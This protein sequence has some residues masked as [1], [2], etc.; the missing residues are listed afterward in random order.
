MFTQL[1]TAVRVVQIRGA[2]AQEAAVVHV[3]PSL[4]IS[5][6]NILTFLGSTP[7]IMSDIPS[8]V[9]LPE[10]LVYRSYITLQVGKIV[11]IFKTLVLTG[12]YPHSQPDSLH[13]T[14]PLT[15]VVWLTPSTKEEIE[16]VRFTVFALIV[17]IQE[18]LLRKD[19]RLSVQQDERAMSSLTVSL[20]NLGMAQESL[21]IA[22][23]TVD[24]YKILVKADEDVYSPYL[25]FALR[26]LSA[27]FAQSGDLVNAYKAITE[28]VTLARRVAAS[29]PT[30]EAQSQLA[31]L[32][33][34]SAYVGRLNEDTTNALQDAE[35]AVQLY[36][37]LFG[38]ATSTLK[39]EVGVVEKTWGSTV[40][41]FEGTHAY[42]FAD[43]L[44]ELHYN[45]SS[46]IRKDE[47]V[48]AGIMA[49]E[50]YSTLG[51]R[52][53]SDCFSVAIASLCLSL[54]SDD[55]RD[56]ISIAEALSY[57]E[58]SVCHYESL[59]QSTGVVP[60]NLFLALAKEAAL[61]S[62]LERFDDA[63]AVCRKTANMLHDY[64]D[65]QCLR[66]Q[67]LRLLTQ[68]LFDSKH[69][70][71]AAVTGEHLLVTFQP[72]LSVCE[73]V[74]IREYVSTSFIW[75]GDYSKAV[76]VAEMSVTSCRALVLQGLQHP[77]YLA[78]SL[79]RLACAFS[80]KKDYNR[81]F[82]EGHTALEMYKSLIA[83]NVGFLTSYKHALELN[84]CIVRD[85]PMEFRSL[86]RSREVVQHCRALVKQFPNEQALFVQC[87]RDHALLLESFDLIAD[88]NSAIEEVLSWFE[89][90]PA[91]DVEL[92]T[93]HCD[94]LI[95]SGRFQRL[96]GCFDRAL[97]HYE[98]IIEIGNPF[99][100]DYSV[101]YNVLWAKVRKSEA[102]Y[103][104]GQ[105][106]Q[107]LG[108]TQD[109]LKFAFEHGLEK[110]PAYT[111][112]LKVASLIHRCS[113]RVDHA[114][115]I[116]RRSIVLDK[117]YSRTP[118]HRIL[119]DL[120]A[121]AGVDV[122]AL[123]IAQE[124]IEATKESSL[125]SLPQVKQWHAEAQYSLAIRLF[126]NKELAQARKFLRQVRSFYEHHSNARNLWFV[127]L[128]ITLRAEGLVEC[129][130]GQHQEGI[131]ARTQ[132]NELRK[133][134]R[135]VFP[136][137]A[138]LVE[139]GLSR[140]MNFATWRNLSTKYRLT[141]G[142]QDEESTCQKE[143]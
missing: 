8:H 135:F 24:L 16:D 79:L 39:A 119:S 32:V 10:D 111:S 85:A 84:M 50:L 15:S 28:A 40:M 37:R 36:I 17:E 42:E 81:A 34:Y 20:L 64:I 45:L 14:G 80:W 18:C 123:G 29:Q 5:G 116:I 140:E 92:A 91:Q 22:Q 52:H 89:Q 4:Q 33:C 126:F 63:Y 60:K 21:T 118:S 101:A 104:T 136:S 31:R 23:C 110:V 100:H 93:L 128:A 95:A 108:E 12:S 55:F 1:G 113:G 120:L 105:N 97:C 49:L 133:R 82:D 98:K 83:E 143:M 112:C 68:N 138:D 99:V 56:V 13:P 62:Q 46:T 109:C 107:A 6:N 117:T 43:A 125:S 26:N 73:V 41:T 53:N 44:K 131:A 90:H 132:L 9:K 102:L 7:T 48:N 38:K 142:H 127:N 88:S 139:V 35:E 30:F 121:D 27:S 78:R 61:L 94:C 25:A 69:H 51:Q 137:L 129:A 96:Q 47:S 114:L 11:A 65:D 58:Q 72:I 77:V 59:G 87:I 122:E 115:P 86:Q 76:Q 67:S 66:V 106:F 134:L 141:C 19:H 130:L 74:D 54:A 75:I 70:A 124:A 2:L 103:Y 3:D 57:L 71:E